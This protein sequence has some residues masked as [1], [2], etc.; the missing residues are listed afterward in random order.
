MTMNFSKNRLAY[1]DALRGI[2]IFGVLIVH[3]FAMA[4]G[5][6]SD[7]VSKIASSGAKGVQLFFIVSAFSLFL[8]LENRKDEKNR[9]RNFFIRRFFRIAPLFYVAIVVYL[10]YYGRGQRYWLGD[11][12]YVTNWN[13]LATS[14]FVNGWYPYWMNSVIGVNWTIAVEMNFYLLVPYLF[15]KINNLTDAI[16]LTVISGSIFAVANPFLRNLNLISDNRLWRDYL[17]FWLPNQFPVFC[18]G[19]VVFFILKR[20]T[21]EVN[22]MGKYRVYL[23]LAAIGLFFS[24]L[25]MNDQAYIIDP[26]GFVFFGLILILAMNPLKLFVNIFWVYLGKISY[27]AYLIHLLMLSM[28]S[29]FFNV[30]FGL[31]LASDHHLLISTFVIFIFTLCFTMFFSS[32]SYYLIEKPGID[33]GNEIIKKLET[34]E[35]FKLIVLLRKLFGRSETRKIEGE[36]W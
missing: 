30:Y 6:I 10:L 26:F 16:L 11:F 5:K 2:A 21:N 15:K 1:I 19:I 36:S 4:N 3:T 22:Q 9:T 18:L 32:I 27:S 25:I 13:I 20:G 23:L 24:G 28:V 34:G 29:K 33:F 14:L 35:E 7:L 12:P 8:S 17:Y 31:G